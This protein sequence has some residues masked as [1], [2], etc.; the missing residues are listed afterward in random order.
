[1]VIQQNKNCIPSQN[2]RV[3]FKLY[4]LLKIEIIHEIK[5]YINLFNQLIIL[6]M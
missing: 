5:N 3:F 1:M 2:E 6:R 4:L